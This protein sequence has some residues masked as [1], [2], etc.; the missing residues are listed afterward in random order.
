[1]A[2]TQQTRV[3][4]YN[5]CEYDLWLARN[6]DFSKITH[7]RAFDLSLV[8]ALPDMPNVIEFVAI[9][10]PMLTA[11]PS[12]PNVIEFLAFNM[13]LVAVLPDMPNVKKFMADKHLTELRS[14]VA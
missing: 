4:F 6:P 13:P 11:F 14:A 1:M 7:F 9:N 10:I 12:M 8:T 3:E 2:A 5:Q